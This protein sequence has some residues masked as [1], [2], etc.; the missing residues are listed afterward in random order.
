MPQFA[1]FELKSAP[2][3]TVL[4]RIPENQARDRE[5]STGSLVTKAKKTFEEALDG[6]KPVVSAVAARISDLGSPDEVSVKMAVTFTAEAGIV[7][8]SA[9]AEG[10]LELSLTWKKTTTQKA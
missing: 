8:S 6:L 1:E 4:V 10:S 9:S 5:I 2:G 7:L 3:C